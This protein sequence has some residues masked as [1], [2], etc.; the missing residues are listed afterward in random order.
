MK[1]SL[2]HPHVVWLPVLVLLS[3]AMGGCS[4]GIVPSSADSGTPTSDGP[5]GPDD[6]V[7]SWSDGGT[8][9]PNDGGKTARQDAGRSDAGDGPVTATGLEGFCEH[10]LECGGTTYATV[11]ACVDDATS[12]WGDCARPELDAFGDCMMTIPCSKWAPE[13]YDPLAT[14]CADEWTGVTNAACR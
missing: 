13:A 5:S 2:R 11:D 8:S 12:Y 10:Y 14:I 9:K 1:R 3:S 4:S 7:V 6:D